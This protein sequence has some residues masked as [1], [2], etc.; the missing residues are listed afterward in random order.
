MKTKTIS[1]AY[2]SSIVA[3]KQGFKKEGCWYLTIEDDKAD[4]NPDGV[5]FAHKN[6][7]SVLEFA[8]KFTHEWSAYSMHKG[9]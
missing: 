9:Q 8:S 6:K 1:Y 4:Y 7:S 5:I 3:T 2:P